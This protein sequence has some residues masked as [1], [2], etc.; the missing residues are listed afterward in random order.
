[1]LLKTNAGVPEFGIQGIAADRNFS[2]VA[3]D[4]GSV[5]ACF[6]GG[7]VDECWSRVVR[8]HNLRGTVNESGSAAIREPSKS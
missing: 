4:R 1:M 6:L 7:L 3:R 2:G 5:L 8:C